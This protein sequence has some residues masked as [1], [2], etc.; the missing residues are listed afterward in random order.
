MREF[1]REFWIEVT[2]SFGM[3]VGIYLLVEEVSIW[4][5]VLDVIES[6]QTAVRQS[7]SSVSQAFSMYVSTLELSD[8]VGFL[9]VVS[10]VVILAV[11]ARRRFIVSDRYVGAFCPKCGSS[12]LRLHRFRSD[13]ILSKILFLK[14]HR[15]QC[16]NS[17]CDWGGLRKPART[18]TY[19]YGVDFFV[20]LTS[21]TPSDK[22]LGLLVL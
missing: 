13:Q 3:I 4:F 17:E 7:F 6:I 19:N 14:F 10:A 5:F 21:D 2:F 11:R 15:Y 9:L 20:S 18:R 16:S 12:L 1:L 22:I 8:L